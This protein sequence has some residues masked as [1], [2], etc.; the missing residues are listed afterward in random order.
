MPTFPLP[1]SG[2]KIVNSCDLEDRAPDA[3]RSPGL[4]LFFHQTAAEGSGAA[5]GFTMFINKDLL[6]DPG[7]QIVSLWWIP[8]LVVH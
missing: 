2:R 8:F 1:A 6:R 5:I 7:F 3:I 4:I